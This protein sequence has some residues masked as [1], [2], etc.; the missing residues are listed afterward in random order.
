MKKFLLL[1][2]LAAL[3]LT[4]CETNTQTGAL[5]GGLIGYGIRGDARGAA[6]GAGIGAVAGAVAD[7]S[8]G[9]PYYGPAPRGYT[10]L[11]AQP[12]YGRRGFVYSPYRRNVIIDV[13]GVSRG[14]YVRCPRSGRVFIY[15]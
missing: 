12:V 6:L 2:T 9:S 10:M 5:A 4:A 14:S 15:R 11:Y 3:T 13:R 8:V 7:A 1:T